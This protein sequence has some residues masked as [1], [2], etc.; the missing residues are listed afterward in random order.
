MI[1]YI[2]GIVLC[3]LVVKIDLII[4]IVARAAADAHPLVTSRRHCLAATMAQAATMLVQIVASASPSAARHTYPFQRF[5]S[6][7]TAVGT[8][9]SERALFLTA[10]P[11]VRLA[12]FRVVAA[13]SV[14]A[15][16]PLRW[17]TTTRTI[18]LVNTV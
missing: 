9:R 12:A 5:G 18:M 13:A 15:A 2:G 11:S 8:C 14:D 3:V 10:V 4:A 16:E 1:P 17:Q 6:F 7:R